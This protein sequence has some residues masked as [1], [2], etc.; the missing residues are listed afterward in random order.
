M[1]PRLT[2]NWE[3]MVWMPCHWSIQGH[4]AASIIAQAMNR[5]IRLKYVGAHR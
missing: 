2:Y 3:F 4:H 5:R 1:K